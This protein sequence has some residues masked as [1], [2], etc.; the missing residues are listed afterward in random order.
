MFIIINSLKILLFNL[1]SRQEMKNSA[2]KP[3]IKDPKLADL[4]QKLEQRRQERL[5]ANEEMK[6]KQSKHSASKIR[7]L[8]KQKV[9]LTL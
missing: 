8:N 4:Q 1:S 5:K 6:M 2:K 7:T 9:N 3:E